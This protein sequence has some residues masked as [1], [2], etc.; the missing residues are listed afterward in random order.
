MMTSSEAVK[1]KSSIDYAAEI[2][3]KEG[4]K[5]FF[6]GASA[7][8]LRAVVGGGVLAVYDQLHLIFLGKKHEGFE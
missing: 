8:I 1:Y 4:V 2:L 7:N 6:K 5:S 3:K